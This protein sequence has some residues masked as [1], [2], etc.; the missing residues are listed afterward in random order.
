MAQLNGDLA[1]A[2]AIELAA[3]AGKYI[4]DTEVR[5]RV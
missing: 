5:K 1:D 3:Q 2:Q 4:T